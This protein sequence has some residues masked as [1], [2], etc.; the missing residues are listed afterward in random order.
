[1]VT[2]LLLD[3]LG[4]VMIALAVIDIEKTK[5]DADSLKQLESEINEERK[6]ESLWSVVG[7][8]LITLGFIAIISAEIM[9][10]IQDVRQ[11]YIQKPLF[12]R[13]QV[14]IR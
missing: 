1:V 11:D 10:W 14:E 13:T 7:V 2:G 12:R 4:V 5:V 9:Q 8:I 6:E 3:V